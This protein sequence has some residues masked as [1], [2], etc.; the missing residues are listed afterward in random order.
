MNDDGNRCNA[1]QLWERI[2]TTRT[3]SPPDCWC[4]LKGPSALSNGTLARCPTKFFQCTKGLDIN[5]GKWIFACRAWV[6]GNECGY[7]G[8]I[9][10]LF[11]FPS[12]NFLFIFQLL[13]L[14]MF[15]PAITS[16]TL[17]VHRHSKEN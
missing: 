12:A 8:K 4:P 9:S 5:I 7:W 15:S 16:S 3:I 10:I 14:I 6:H 1:H 17:R 11:L 2:Y 13:L